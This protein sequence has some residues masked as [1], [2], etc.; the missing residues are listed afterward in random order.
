MCTSACSD[1]D[2]KFW[3]EPEIEVAVAKGLRPHRLKAIHRI[4]EEHK[5][6]LA[7]AWHEHLDS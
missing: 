5:D 1:G 7:D 3:L 6:E 2:A 4:I